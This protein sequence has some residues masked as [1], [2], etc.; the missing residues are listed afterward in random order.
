MSYDAGRILIMPKGAWNSATEYEILD[1][2]TYQRGAYLSKVSSN[3]NH[4]PLGDNEQDDYWY[5]FAHDGNGISSIEKTNSQTVDGRIVD[6]YTIHYTDS[7]DSYFSVVN[8]K[9]GLGIGDMEKSV[10]D[11]NN[12]GVVDIMD[13]VAP[14][15]EGATSSDDY[16]FGDQIIHNKKLYTVI[17]ST[18]NEGDT[19]V[20][21]G[22]SANISEV[23]SIVAQLAGLGGG[24]VVTL[25]TAQ[26]NAL[27]PEQKADP[28][29]IYFITDAPSS[30]W[31]AFEID[32]DNTLSGLTA[33]NVQDAIDETVEEIG[34]VRDNL[35]NPN[36]LDNPWFTV[37]QRGA[38][39][40]TGTG[41]YTVDRW[42][43][44]DGNYTVGVSNDVVTLTKE[45]NTTASEFVEYFEKERLAELEGKPITLSV[46]LSD[47]TIH[48]ATAI[49]PALTSTL[50]FFLS[51]IVGN[52]A[53]RLGVRNSGNALVSFRS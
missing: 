52:F 12:D 43:I 50:N 31:Q 19:F 28:T 8:G 47:G 32:Y 14:V 27:T 48:S 24:S 44:N 37:N 11:A 13:V 3:L 20:T 9:D 26:Y 10:Y 29:K 33:D 15:E 30:D 22:A 46:M 53:I 40:Y 25:T 7:Q 21:S 39:S 5:L 4:T 18:I 38:S 34:D 36:L 1:V 42:K 35:T 45:N 49:M 23:G 51:V 6:T 2:V 41:V 16:S 17:A